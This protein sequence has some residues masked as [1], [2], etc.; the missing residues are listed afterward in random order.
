MAGRASR[1]LALVTKVLGLAAA[2]GLVAGGAALLVVHTIGRGPSTS[3]T[4]EVKAFLTDIRNEKYT[5][6]YDR[7]CQESANIK[8]R[9]VFVGGLAEA[10]KRGHGIDSFDIGVSFTKETARLTSAG[11]TVTFRDGKELA[12]TFDVQPSADAASQRCIVPG[13][14][15]TGV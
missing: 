6:A 1:S 15:L 13:D 9:D 12:V 14:D 8:P 7:L 3:A 2:L 5:Q 4:R 10:R 11:G